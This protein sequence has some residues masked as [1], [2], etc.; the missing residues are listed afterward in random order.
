MSLQDGPT[1]PY[2]RQEDP[3]TDR[4]CG[5]AALCM[6]YRSFGHS[7]TQ[8]DVWPRIS[9]HDRRGSMTGMTYLMTQDALARGFS[10]LAVQSRH[11]LQVLRVCRESGI[12]AV[13]NHRLRADSPEGHYTVLVDVDA[14]SVT[15]HDPWFGPSRRMSHAE[16]LDLWLPRFAGSEITGN[17][18]IALAA[19]ETPA[20]PCSRCGSAIPPRA[21]CPG[22][23]KSV[24]LQPASVLGCIGAGCSA[25]L[26]NRVFCPFCNRDLSPGLESPQ[27]QAGR[28]R[29][30]AGVAALDLGALF[31]ELDKFTSHILSFP[32]AAGNPDIRQ[33][34]DFIN[35]SKERLRLA[36]SEDVGRRRVEQG[37]AE[38]REQKFQQDED[39]LRKKKE[40]I[41]RPSAPADGN[42][43]GRALLKDLGLA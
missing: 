43:L 40:E 15:V 24:P 41:D 35:E 6:A 21:D 17:V 28:T 3:Q 8:T 23:G 16:L 22:C 9:K 10:A 27:P 14:E 11:P 29:P 2:E 18:L 32:A 1:I 31:A 26:W 39:A 42:A 12:R 7:V 34:I 25:R 19:G 5:A 4:L 37:E 36:Q 13:L 20:A 30:A 38:Q 33:Q